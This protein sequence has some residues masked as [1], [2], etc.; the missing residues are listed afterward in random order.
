MTTVR[1]TTRRTGAESEHARGRPRDPQVDQ[2][3]LDAATS[4]LVEGGL[5]AMSVSEVARRTGISRATVYLRWPTRASLLGATAKSAVGGKPYPLSG[6]FETDMPELIDF[7]RRTFSG[8]GFV[9]V[10]PELITAVLGDPPTADLEDLTPNRPT[11]ASEARAAAARGAI[12]PGLDPDLPFDI[13]LGTA[14]AYML[15][16]REGPP[17]AYTDQLAQV[18]LRGMRPHDGPIGS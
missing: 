3:I 9:H 16:H 2:A 6:D 13:I 1:T 5:G 10:L 14:I 17:K 12:D 8:P 4:L 11:F 18:V 7:V 15:A